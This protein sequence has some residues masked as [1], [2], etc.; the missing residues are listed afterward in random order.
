MI[1]ESVD[2]FEESGGT[3]GNRF[4]GGLIELGAC[5]IMMTKAGEK[6]N[7]LRTQRL[8]FPSDGAIQ[9]LPFIE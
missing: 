8:P 5:K 2:C 7:R 4:L 9:S 3:F 6:M 1:I